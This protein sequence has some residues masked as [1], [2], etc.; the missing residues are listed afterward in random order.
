MHVEIEKMLDRGNVPKRLELLLEVLGI[1]VVILFLLIGQKSLLALIEPELPVRLKGIANCRQV[2]TFCLH[3]LVFMKFFFLA[4]KRIRS[5]ARI[6]VG[7]VRVSLKILGRK[8]T[9]FRDKLLF[10]GTVHKVTSI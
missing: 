1:S 8:L 9:F 3:E 7:K 6:F 2:L 10:L 5:L 4:V